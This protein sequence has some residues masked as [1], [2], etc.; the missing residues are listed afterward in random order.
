MDGRTDRWTDGRTDGRIYRFPCSTGLRLLRIHPEPLPCSP[1]CYHYKIPEQGMGT[2]DHILPLGDWLE[3]FHCNH[4]YSKFLFPNFH[5]L[6]ETSIIL[7]K[8]TKINIGIMVTNVDR[9]LNIVWKLDQW[10]R[11]L[12]ASKTGRELGK[13]LLTFFSLHRLL[14]FNHMTRA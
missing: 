4:S 1:N 8:S 11:L 2:E 6:D 10:P 3:L 12:W 5:Q 9:C 13:V 14:D 7:W